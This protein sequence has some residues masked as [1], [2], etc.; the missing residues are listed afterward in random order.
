VVVTDATVAVKVAVVAP[1]ATDTLAGAVTAVSLLDKVTFWP[2][3][4]A[5]EVNETVQLDVPA[6]VKELVLQERADKVGVEVGDEGVVTAFNLI[7]VDF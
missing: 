2:P 7:A 1:D 4:G 6:P 3:V 5:A